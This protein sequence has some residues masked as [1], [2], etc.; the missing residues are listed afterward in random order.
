MPKTCH[1]QAAKGQVELQAAQYHKEGC[2][3]NWQMF[4]GYSL[5]AGDAWLG[6]KKGPFRRAHRYICRREDFIITESDKILAKDENQ[7]EDQ[8]GA[9]VRQP[10]GI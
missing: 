5:G 8:E 4:F 2:P 10:R 9:G 1:E 3:Q 6:W 7:A